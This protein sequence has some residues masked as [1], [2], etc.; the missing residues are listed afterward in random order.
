MLRTAKAVENQAEFTTVD[1]NKIQTRTHRGR[2]VMEKEKR[3]FL[4]YTG[5]THLSNV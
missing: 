5:M 2:Y 4:I 3:V 1:M